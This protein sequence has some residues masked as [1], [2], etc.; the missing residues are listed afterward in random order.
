MQIRAYVRDIF[1]EAVDQGLL[2]KNPARKLKPPANLRATDETVLTWDQLA[3]A[4]EKLDLRDR[5]L[6]RL[7]ITNAL[8]PGELF[9]PRWKCHHVETLSLSIMETGLQGE[10]PALRQDERKSAG[11]ADLGGRVEG[12]RSLE[13]GQPGAVQQTE[14]EA[15]P[16]AVGPG[17]VHVS[18]PVWRLDGLKQLPQAGPA[19]AGNGA[20]PA[21]AYV[22][23]HPADDRHSGLEE[24]NSE[25]RARGDGAYAAGNDDR[26]LHAADSG[27]CARDGGFA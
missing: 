18:W 17:S 10:G 12:P 25:G 14:E 21:R 15:W 1:A 19:Q 11:G 20:R 13:T 16:V 3:A 22:S 6:L 24:G 4:V 8:R 2:S 27:E 9:A 23:D 5:V 26:R 7:D